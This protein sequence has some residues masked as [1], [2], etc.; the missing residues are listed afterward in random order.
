[1]LTSRSLLLRSVPPLSAEVIDEYI[2]LA[3]SYNEAQS[4]AYCDTVMSAMFPHPGFGGDAASSA[5]SYPPDP[6]AVSQEEALSYYAGLPSEP[7]LVYRTGKERWSPPR[8][9]EAYRRLKELREVFGHPI[10]EVWHHDL[11]WKI[12]S[13]MDDHRIRFTTIDVVRFKKVEVDEPPEH[14]EESENEE[15]VKPKKP[16]LSPVTIWIGVFPGSTTATAAHHAAQSV[17]ALLQGC[18]ITDVDVD[19]RES[20]YTRSVGPRLLRPVRDRDPLAEVVTPLTPALGLCISTRARPDAQGT[21][22]LYLAEGD[23]SNRLLGLSCRHVLIGPEAGNFDYSY[24]PGAPPKD[25]L[26]LGKGGYANLVDSIKF[27]IAG[28]GISAKLYRNE[29]ESCKEQ[30]KGND[31]ADVAKAEE[32]RIETEKLLDKAGEATVELAGFLDQVNKEWR[33]I[34]N[35]VIG[36]VLRSP[37]IGLGVSEQH[38]TED[39]GVFVVDRAKLGDGFQGNKI[40]LGTKM[41]PGEFTLK[42]FPRGDD[43]WKFEYP[44]GRLLPLEGVI[45]DDLMRVPDMRGENSERCLLVVKR[46]SATGTT[47][48]RA[49]G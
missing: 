36:R 11:A 18:Q 44:I 14:E 25:V 46:G 21:M 16:L 40:D 20:I 7:R 8:G 39:W 9:P 19:F 1:M 28:E 27:A 38:F 29:I 2:R 47:L 23:G 48:G 10:T 3:W 17:L 41:K 12:V 15:T 45:T 42:C 32:Y 33:K 35:R 31:A 6:H 49:N 5:T 22:A 43:N 37:P 34:R 4:S 13:I 24:H 30:E 26:L